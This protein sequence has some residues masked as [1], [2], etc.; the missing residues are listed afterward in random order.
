MPLPI[1]LAHRMAERL[2]EVRKAGVIPYLRPDGKTQVTFDY[3]D[4]RPVRL[5]TVLISTQHAARHRP[6]HHDPAG[7]DRA[8]HQAGRA[9]AVRATT[10]T[11]ATSTRRARSCSADPTATPASPAARSSSTPTAAWPATAAAPSAAR[12]PRRSTARPP[13]PPAGWP[14]T[15]S[16][17]GAAQPLRGAG[18]LRHRRGAAGVGAG[19]DVRDGHGRPRAASS[20]PSA[21]SSTCGP[22]PS[23]TSSTCA[24]PSTARPRPTGTSAG[25]SRVHLG[26]A[27]NL[28]L[29][30]GGR[31][32]A[33]SPSSAALRLA[34]LACSH[35]RAPVR[36]AGKAGRTGRR[37]S[38]WRG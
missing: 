37:R 13:T 16:P 28:E 15:W 22:R 23:S 31:R 10:T 32:R 1:W 5:R 14:S 24:S 17:S 35:R 4:G 7:P 20:R 9:G 2:A 34:P 6:R 25:T 18:G 21:R 33:S 27:G 19:R 8:R 36:C 38:W 3:E 26:A 11:S 29:Q 12:T 30:G